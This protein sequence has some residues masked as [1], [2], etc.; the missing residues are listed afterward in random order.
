VS[1]LT[2]A[3][4]SSQQWKLLY[5]PANKNYRLSRFTRLKRVNG[6]YWSGSHIRRAGIT[7]LPSYGTL[8]MRLNQLPSHLEHQL[9]MRVTVTSRARWQTFLFSSRQEHVAALTN[10]KPT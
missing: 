1:N 8:L 5:D 4:S 10:F 7:S 2:K 3:V 9:V 6:M